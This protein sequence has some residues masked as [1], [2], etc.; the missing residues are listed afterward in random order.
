MDSC[1]HLLLPLTYTTL[2]AFVSLPSKQQREVDAPVLVAALELDLPA[3]MQEHRIEDG[4]AVLAVRHG[5]VAV[6]LLM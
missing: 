3:L 4:G 1:V 6:P 2:L 5:Q